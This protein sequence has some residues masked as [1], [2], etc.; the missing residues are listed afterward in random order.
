MDG[1]NF[2][3]CSYFGGFVDWKGSR[4]GKACKH[5][6]ENVELRNLRETKKPSP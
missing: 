6:R 5:R 2:S 1:G 3:S 4:G